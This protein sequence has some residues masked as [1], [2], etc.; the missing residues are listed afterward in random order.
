MATTEMNYVEGGGTKCKVDTF[1]ITGGQTKSIDV[2]FQPKQLSVYK[3]NSSSDNYGITCIYDENVT[4]SAYW[5]EWN[6]SGGNTLNLTRT[7]LPSYNP[8]KS[9]D[10][11][12]F[13]IELSSGTT[14]LEGTYTYIAVG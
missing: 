4:T 5:R 9:I 2:G 12:G 8:L 1:S 10:A 13:T 7:A 14:A 11:N 3:I 6:F